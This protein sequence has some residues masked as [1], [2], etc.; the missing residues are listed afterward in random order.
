MIENKRRCKCTCERAPRPKPPEFY[1]DQA[2]DI[3]APAPK[4]SALAEEL[5]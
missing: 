4:A 2:Y 5:C 3:P 1:L